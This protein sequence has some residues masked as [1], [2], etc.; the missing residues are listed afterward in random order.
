M[1]MEHVKSR[2]VNWHSINI[3]P[4]NIDKKILR[5]FLDVSL[6]FVELVDKKF[7]KINQNLLRTLKINK[8]K[9]SYRWVSVI[10]YPFL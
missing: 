7:A 2:A 5:D 8:I 4:E 3:V 6:K 9:K 1:G 10:I